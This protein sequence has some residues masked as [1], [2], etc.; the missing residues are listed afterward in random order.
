MATDFTVIE[1]VRQHFGDDPGGG[2]PD[3][4]GRDRDELWAAGDIPYVGLAKDY[5]FSCPSIDG[6]QWAVL[7]FLTF[8][9]SYD[10]IIRINGADVPGGITA[11]PVF[12][13]IS[14]HVPLWNA[15][16]QLIEPGLLGDENVL[17]VESVADP[18]GNHDDFVVDNIVIWFKTKE[19]KPG[20]RP[21][22]GG[23]RG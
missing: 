10:N 5:P 6:S 9:V 15:E 4:R 8:G 2:L 17:H 11:G 16:F 14:P 20:T 18:T 1:A 21:T 22:V 23:A 19:T 12:V 13:D 7:Q 3:D